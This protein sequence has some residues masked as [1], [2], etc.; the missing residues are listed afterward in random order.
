MDIGLIVFIAAVGLQAGPH[1]VDAYNRSGGA[2]FARIFVAGM[3]VTT[4][5]LAVG[6]I[7]ARYVLK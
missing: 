6:A 7:L 3:I 1:A 2:Y 4:V 5:P